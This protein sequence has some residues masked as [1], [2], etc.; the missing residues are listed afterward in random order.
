MD[1]PR[2]TRSGWIYYAAVVAAGLIALA[3]AVSDLA[4]HYAL[5]DRSLIFL[6]A[7]TI[8]GVFATIRVPAL[9]VTLSVAEAFFF[10]VVLLYGPG[11]GT[12]VV[13][14]EALVIWW[15]LVRRGNPATKI[16]FTLCANSVA[17]ALGGWIFFKLANVSPLAAGT[18]DKSDVASL[19]LPLVT[20]AAVVLLGQFVVGRDCNCL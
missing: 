4:R 13:A 2:L 15:R 20:L 14:L 17:M 5:L 9:P 16:I 19:I 1:I 12:L 11:A 3:W 7:F 6:V 10:M 18:F 8:L